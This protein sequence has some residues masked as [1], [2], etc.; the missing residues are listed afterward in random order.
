MSSVSGTV[1]LGKV[2]YL[3]GSLKNIV[4][5]IESS[6]NAKLGNSGDLT[7]SD[8]IMMSSTTSGSGTHNLSIASG[9]D[10]NAIFKKE[11]TDEDF[12]Y[13]GTLSKGQVS[14]LTYTT[15]TI[16]RSS[17]GVYG[18]SG[19]FPTP[20]CPKGLAF[21]TSKFST[22]KASTTVIVASTDTRSNVTL[23]ESDGVTV[24]DG[25]ITI[26]DNGVGTLTCNGTGEFVVSSTAN[27]VGVV[28]GNGTQLRILAP[29]STRLICWN[30]GNT[31]SSLSGTASV[32]WHRRNGTTGT[33]SVPSGTPTALGAGTSSAFE[34]AG[35]VILRSNVP[36]SCH[37]TSDG[38]GDQ[39][40][41][42]LPFDMLA[43]NFPNPGY[44]DNTDSFVAI[45]SPYVGSAKV[46]NSSGT[47]VATFQITRNGGT[48]TSYADQQY[49]ATG[50]WSPSDDGLTSLE[51]GFIKTTVPCMCVM[52][53]KGSS[54]WTGT[55]GKEMLIL[56][57]TPLSCKALF[58]ENDSDM[59]YHRRWVGSSVNWAVA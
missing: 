18:L 35:C 7:N 19:P 38:D 27:I 55:D 49:P 59:L 26:D 13:I 52:N 39:S 33:T 41:P 15:G 43:H 42:G 1:S 8:S 30:N 34:A 53:F 22:T 24:A 50:K 57:N 54:V 44:L 36:I 16:I 28:N 47:I 10:H 45:G 25:P 51:G 23:F 12:V 17:R 40:I 29:M 32:N 48:A 31:V 3:E 2:E 5:D 9:L 4:N 58:V 46:Y 14:N 11:S 56:G 6:L 37:T 20:L 21:K